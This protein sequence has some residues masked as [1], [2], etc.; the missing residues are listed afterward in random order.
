[1]S[2]EQTPITPARDR[3]DC[4]CSCVLID[5]P[6]EDQRRFNSS[7]NP[8]HYQAFK[9]AAVNAGRRDISPDGDCQI[10]QGS[11]WEY[12]PPDLPADTAEQTHKG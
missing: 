6:P 3:F 7:R 12:Q 1:M 4:L 11:G 8:D 5:C 10:C 2:A 9:R